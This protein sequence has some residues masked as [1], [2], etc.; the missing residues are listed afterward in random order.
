MENL[1]LK[2]I[3]IIM[4]CSVILV[5]LTISLLN[6]PKASSEAIVMRM[7]DR[8]KAISTE[9]AYWVGTPLD[10]AIVPC[11]QAAVDYSIPPETF[12]SIAFAESSF[13]HFPEMKHNP[14]GVSDSSEED[15]VRRYLSWEEACDDFGRMM[16]EMYFDLGYNTPEKI[17]RRYVGWNNP[18]WLLA[19]NTYWEI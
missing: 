7:S 8:E 13:K 15:N 1:Q 2:G 19:V 9:F 14:W 12:V 3:V 5:G 6:W 10:K 11:Y 18:N 4:L 16:K 17:H